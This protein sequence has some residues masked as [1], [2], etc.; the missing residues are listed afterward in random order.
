VSRILRQGDAGEFKPH[1][2]PGVGSTPPL[3]ESAPTP[4][5]AGRRALE[6]ELGRLRQEAA[7]RQAQLEAQQAALERLKTDFQAAIAH[8]K[9][10]CID[11][12]ALPSLWAKSAELELVRLATRIAEKV[13]RRE[14]ELRPESVVSTVREAVRAMPD[15]RAVSVRVNEADFSR[16]QRI[17]AELG[18]SGLEALSLEVSPEVEPGGCI[19]VSETGAL[20]ANP[21]RQLELIEE[22]LLEHA[23]PREV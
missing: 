20:N 19:V 11:V 3:A 4:E 1:V 13:V 10:V 7:A 5:D 22:A 15:R 23:E 2:F 12:E 16:L 21:S 6:A 17:Q 14:L 9:R 8:F 18:L